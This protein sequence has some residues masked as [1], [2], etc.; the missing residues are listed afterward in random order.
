MFI[1]WEIAHLLRRNQLVI[2]DG[3]RRPTSNLGSKFLLAS[4][5][6][7]FYVLS[8]LLFVPVA[9][10]QLATVC[11]L[12]ANLCIIT[13]PTGAPVCCFCT[14]SHRPPAVFTWAPYWRTTSATK[15]FT[16]E[17]RFQ[18]STKRNQFVVDTHGTNLPTN[19]IDNRSKKIQ[20]TSIF[21]VEWSK[22]CVFTFTDKTKKKK[23]QIIPRRAKQMLFKRYRLSFYMTCVTTVAIFTTITPLSFI[24]LI[25]PRIICKHY[26]S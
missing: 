12:S 18:T 26:S 7:N 1:N 22:K 16:Q 8:R 14:V 5:I 6:V 2:L 9:T 4:K 23:C 11:S 20:N 13:G 24:E 21:Y 10:T 17:D 25:S 19:H 3:Y 15:W